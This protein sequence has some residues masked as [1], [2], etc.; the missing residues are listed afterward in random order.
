MEE[1][2]II[3]EEDKD[4][5]KGWFDAAPKQTFETLTEFIRHVMND[6]EHDYGTVCH[7]IGACCVATAWACNEMEGARGGITGF[8]A[9]FVM[10]DFIRHWMY[11][12]NKCGMKLV[13]YDNLLYP[14]YES[15]FDKT[16]P[17]R[18]WESVQEEAKRR[19]DEVYRGKGRCADAVF[20]HWESI[21][22]GE[23]PF[24]MT[25]EG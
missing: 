14:Q 16:I 25:V 19:C 6:Y 17:T 22:N 23:V 21:A 2:K 24:G 4:E 11:E 5:I 13:D 7:A 12:S 20:D 10:W 15:Y 9:G 18:V 1:K 8:Q 3:T